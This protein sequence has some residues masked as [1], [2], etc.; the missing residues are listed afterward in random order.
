MY[1]LRPRRVPPAAQ[2]LFA[3]WT[4]DTSSQSRRR[5]DRVP[6]PG[7]TPQVLYKSLFFRP[8]LDVACRGW[9]TGLPLRPG[10]TCCSFL[11]QILAADASEKCEQNMNDLEAHAFRVSTLA[12]SEVFSF[13][14]E[15]DFPASAMPA[16]SD[17]RC[18]TMR[19]R[20]GEDMRANLS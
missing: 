3:R 8:V 4:P 13:V 17:G 9:S 15:T 11:V 19:E 20:T 2:P 16:S 7:H 5:E 6:V 18:Q 10:A 1:P 14:V 12:T